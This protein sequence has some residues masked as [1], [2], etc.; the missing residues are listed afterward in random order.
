MIGLFQKQSL[1]FITLL[2]LC[3]T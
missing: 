3:C 2:N 1:S